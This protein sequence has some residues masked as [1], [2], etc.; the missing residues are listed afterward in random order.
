MKK[1]EFLSLSAPIHADLLILPIAE[2][3]TIDPHLKKTDKALYDAIMF[4]IKREGF[5]GKLNQQIRMT[6]NGASS[7][8][9]VWIVG[10]GSNQQLSSVKLQELGGSLLPAISESS[11]AIYDDGSEKSEIGLHLT[12]GMMQRAWSFHKYKTQ[13]AMEHDFSIQL[14]SQSPDTYKKQFQYY[15]HL[16]EGIVLARDLTSEPASTLYPK[17]YAERCESLKKCGIQV[18][19]LDASQLKEIGAHAILA[20]GKGSINPPYIVVLHWNGGPA[21]QKPVALV[22]KGVCYDSGGINIKNTHLAEMKW[23]K[24]GAGAVVG[25]IQ[26]LALMKAPVNVVGVIGLVENMPDGGALKP[27]DVIQTLAGI[28]VEVVDTDNEGRLV[29]ADCLSYSKRFSPRAIVDLGTLTLE[30]FGALGS[31]YGGLFCEDQKLVDSLVKAG[32]TSGEKLWQLPMGEAFAKQIESP[33]ADI[34]NI[35]ILGFGESSAAAEFLKCFVDEKT[36]WAHLDIAGV[37]WTQ[38]DKPLFRQGVTGF[39]VR[40][41]VEWLTKTKF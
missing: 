22:G 28:T 13:P 33:V 21:D 40:L 17:T 20:V 26:A 8:T 24:A 7:I 18:D 23:D 36:P 37:A 34:K 4:N 2:G 6:T 12:F 41:L 27:S 32:Q 35:G 11:L 9:H 30:T 3:K 25:T 10:L 19:V 29:L 16:F 1:V 39:G 5:T 31:E 15:Q 14:L 38:E